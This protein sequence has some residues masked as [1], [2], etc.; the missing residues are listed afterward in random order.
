MLSSAKNKKQKKLFVIPQQHM[1]KADLYSACLVD[2]F[3]RG[4]TAGKVYVKKKLSLFFFFSS[5]AGIS[6]FLCCLCFQ[7]A[8][9]LHIHQ[10]LYS[11]TNVSLVVLCQDLLFLLFRRGLLVQSGFMSQN[12][13]TIKGDDGGFYFLQEETYPS[14][15]M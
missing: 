5:T 10:L 7:T 3:I 8:A 14:P 9:T 6:L 1:I 11:S 4:N 13:R 12:M 2:A 15:E